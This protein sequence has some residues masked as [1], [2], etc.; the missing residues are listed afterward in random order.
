MTPKPETSTTQPAVASEVSTPSK[1]VGKWTLPA[2]R[3][4]NEMQNP[5]ATILLYS[6][7]RWGKTHSLRQLPVGSTLILATE[8][9]KTKGL[10]TLADI[11]H[12]F[13]PINGEKTMTMVLAELGRRKDG[14]Y[15][16][17]GPKPEDEIGPFEWVVL[18]SLSNLGM[19]WYDASLKAR[20]WEMA[21]DGEDGKDPRQ[22]YSY[23]TERGRQHVK[24]LLDIDA[25][26]LMIARE[27]VM[28][29]KVGRESVFSF[30][31]ELPGQQL[32]RSITG[33]PEAT[34][35]GVFQAGRPVLRT[36]NVGKTV[37]GV[38]LPQSMGR[39][40]EFIIPDFIAL[41]DAILGDASA[42]KRLTPAKTEEPN[43]GRPQARR[44]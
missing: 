34:V 21:W 11:G 3:K 1:A 25:H 26:V 33:W 41:K 15:Y 19:I 18:D 37:A 8:I 16:R 35:H 10:N 22:A 2:L 29:E 17:N 20:G 39:L 31:P 6:T 23:I 36:R 42:I 32:P 30:A 7:A 40:P 44:R 43:A 24:R 4:T 13:L 28:E 27:Q 9:G 14:C 38:R 5:R 12:F